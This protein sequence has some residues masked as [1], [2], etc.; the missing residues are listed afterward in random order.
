VIPLNETNGI[1]EWV[2]N[3]QPLRTILSK[4]YKEKLG[5]QFMT[6]EELK[7]FST[8]AT[9]AKGNHV[10]Y[11]TLLKRHPAVFAEWFVRN[12]PDPQAWFMAR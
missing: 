1:I 2:E 10:K 5:R 4:L 7:Q 11:Q 9:D 6:G 8:S 12:F 3:L